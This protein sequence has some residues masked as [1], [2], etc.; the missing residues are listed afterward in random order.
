MFHIKSSAVLNILI[1]ISLGPGLVMHSIK[2]HSMTPKWPIG[3]VFLSFCLALSLS[4]TCIGSNYQNFINYFFSF[5]L[6]VRRNVNSNIVPNNCIRQIKSRDTSLLGSI[7]SHRGRCHTRHLLIF[8][9]LS[10]S[11]LLQMKFKT[12]SSSFF[13]SF[14]STFVRFGPSTKTAFGRITLPKKS[15]IRRLIVC[16]FRHFGERLLTFKR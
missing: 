13:P 11:A 15:H 9:L 10:N 14:Y 1:T 8:L 12:I 2:R 3:P 16:C 7:V 6:L 4:T 5:F